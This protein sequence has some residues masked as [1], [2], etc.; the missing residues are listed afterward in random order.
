[1]KF[2]LNNAISQKIQNVFESFPEIRE[3][4][5]YG[6]RALGNYRKGSDI[7]MTIKGELSFDHLIQIEKALDD[8]MLPYT[9]DLSIYSKLSNEELVEHIDRKG[10][11]FYNRNTV[12]YR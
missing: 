9:F 7:D 11:I 4:I 5:I 6:S 10:K 1:M 2:G 3:A 8:L 12:H